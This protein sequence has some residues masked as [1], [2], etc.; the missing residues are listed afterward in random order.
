MMCY[1]A[2]RRGNRICHVDIASSWDVTMIMKDTRCFGS[3]WVNDDENGCH[4]HGSQ[5]T[6]D[7]YNML[8]AFGVEEITLD[9]LRLVEKAYVRGQTHHLK[10]S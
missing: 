1:Y 9:V 7:E 3:G 8:D 4:Y 5:I 10:R 6:E 2:I